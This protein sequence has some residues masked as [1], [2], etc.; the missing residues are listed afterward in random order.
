MR[1]LFELLGD[2]VGLAAL[3]LIFWFGLMLAHASEPQPAPADP[4]ASC[5][6]TC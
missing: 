6:P 1:L 5:Q 2:A 4:L 3:A